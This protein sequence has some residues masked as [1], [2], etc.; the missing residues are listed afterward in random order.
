[1]LSCVQEETAARTAATGS[2]RRCERC[3]ISA[4]ADDIKLRV[5]SRCRNVFYCS[6]ECQKKAWKEEHKVYCIDVK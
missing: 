2:G 5:C 3:K 6:R 4:A 1:M